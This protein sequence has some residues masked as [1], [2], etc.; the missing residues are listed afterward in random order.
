ME[1]HRASKDRYFKTSH[2][3]PLPQSER[4][5]FSGL[6]YFP[7]DEQYQFELPLNEY[8]N[9]EIIEME[10]SSGGIKQFK[11]IGYLTFQLNEVSTDIH[12]YQSSDNPD[13]FFVPFRDSTSG[14]ETY[15][16]GRYLDIESDDQVFQLDFNLAYS[17]LCAYSDNYACPLPPFENWLQIPIRAGEKDFHVS[18]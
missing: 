2:H 15:G 17:P 10:V 9:P 8:D 5:A 18:N 11:R 16:A 3:S 1:L 14:E 7:I 6:D 4:K 12:V 13:H